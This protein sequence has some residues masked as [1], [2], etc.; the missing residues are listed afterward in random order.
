MP[1]LIRQS[2]SS[3]SS[4]DGSFNDDGSVSSS[5]VLEDMQYPALSF[6]GYSEK[7]IS[8]QLEPIAVI[9]M[10]KYCVSKIV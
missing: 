4:S 9:G 7:P 1:G 5:V 6:P 8:K 10:G 2:Y 3:S